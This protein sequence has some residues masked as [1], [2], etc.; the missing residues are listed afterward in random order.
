MSMF[1]RLLEKAEL[2][3]A[4]PL[5]SYSAVLIARVG[6]GGVGRVGDG[7]IAA[8]YFFAAL[9]FVVGVLALIFNQGK[10]RSRFSIATHIIAS[11]A[12]ATWL[13]LHLTGTVYSHSS[14]FSHKFFH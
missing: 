9:S 12:I 10:T 6:A 5:L 7:V 11:L 1:G 4:L 13:A 3:I 8:A 14:M 2:L